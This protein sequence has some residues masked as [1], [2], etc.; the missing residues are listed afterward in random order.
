MI[1]FPPSSRKGNHLSKMQAFLR[2]FQPGA[3]THC[4]GRFATCKTGGAYATNVPR[5]HWLNAAALTRLRREKTDVH[6]ASFFRLHFIPAS[7]RNSARQKP[8]SIGTG[9][10][11]VRDVFGRL[12]ISLPAPSYPLRCRSRWRLP[13]SPAPCR[14][15]SHHGTCRSCT[16]RSCP[17]SASARCRPG[18]RTAG[19]R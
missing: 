6:A 13:A 18:H 5:V 4:V 9:L 19:E 1:T 2:I 15:S 17:R 16:Q 3:C 7:C 14:R 12:A 11:V 8:G 10:K